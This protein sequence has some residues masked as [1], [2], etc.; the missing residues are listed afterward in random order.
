[1]CVQDPVEEGERFRRHGL[2]G[3]RHPEHRYEVQYP[4][5]WRT[6]VSI[7]SSEVVWVMRKIGSIPI[8]LRDLHDLFR[9]LDRHI[10][11]KNPVDTGLVCL[12]VEPVN[13]PTVDRV[14]VR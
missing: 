3:T 9:F 13:T 7:R 5:A 4:R 8:L 11:D 2:P 10:R 14:V 12:A 1:M 6:I